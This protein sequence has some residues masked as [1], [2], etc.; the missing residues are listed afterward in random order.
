M[1]GHHE[2]AGQQ[3]V[4]DWCPRISAS[5]RCSP[6]HAGTHL[7]APAGNT[8]RRKKTGWRPGQAHHN[9]TAV[10]R[11]FV[12]GPAL[13]WND[14]GTL[15][16][17][18]RRRGEACLA[19]C[20]VTTRRRHQPRADFT[21][22]PILSGSRKRQLRRRGPRSRASSG[23]TLGT[24]PRGVTRVLADAACRVGQMA[25]AKWDHTRH[26]M[27]HGRPCH[28]REWHS[29]RVWRAE[30]EQGRSVVFGSWVESCR[31]ES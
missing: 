20:V 11:P 29:N 13:V 28:N 22:G 23:R 15:H 10:W 7:R 2:V 30:S 1:R 17:P 19:R 5:Q 16:A 24:L 21:S 6:D 25:L 27:A 31:E 4:G 14:G 18:F 8:G 26:A 12:N 3:A 9:R